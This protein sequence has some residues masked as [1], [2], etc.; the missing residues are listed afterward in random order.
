[1]MYQQGQQQDMASSEIVENVPP[2]HKAAAFALITI[3][4]VQQSDEKMAKSICITNILYAAEHASRTRFEKSSGDNVDV[5]VCYGDDV[6]DEESWVKSTDLRAMT[7]DA[8]VVLMTFFQK[9]AG[10]S[11]TQSMIQGTFRE[12]ARKNAME[13]FKNGK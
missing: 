8:L 6:D 11:P 4:N 10:L 9:K 7:L 1:M 3:M 12:L 13:E 5:A 2:Y